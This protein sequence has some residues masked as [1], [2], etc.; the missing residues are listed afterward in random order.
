MDGSPLTTDEFYNDLI[1]KNSGRNSPFKERNKLLLGLA[2][3]CGLR[4]IELTQIT[5]GLFVSPIGNLNE[6]VVLPEAITYDGYERPF[7]LSNEQL[8]TLFTDYIKWLANN[9]INRT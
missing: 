5:I 8:Q 4:E 9:G 7:L 1:A 6:F 2:V 3:L